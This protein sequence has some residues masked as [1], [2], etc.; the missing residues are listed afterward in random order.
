MSWSKMVSLELDDEDQLD[1]IMPYPMSEK[2]KYP[3][4]L[5]ICLTEKELSKLDLDADCDVGDIIDIRAFARVTSVS[6]NEMEDG[7]SCC[8]VELQIEEIAVEPEFSPKHPDQD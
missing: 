5:R 7:K 2:P 3:F 1:A 4:G 8:R 6:T